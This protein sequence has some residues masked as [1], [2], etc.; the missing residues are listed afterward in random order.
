M[1]PFTVQLVTKG[2]HI[3]QSTAE[4]TFTSAAPPVRKA[5]FVVS[6]SK[7]APQLEYAGLTDVEIPDEILG[8]VDF[9]TYYKRVEYK[10][11]PDPDPLLTEKFRWIQCVVKNQTQFPIQVQGPPYFDSGR[12][13]TPP[14]DIE[15]FD[16]MVFSCS[17]GDESLAGV[18]GGTAFRIALDLVTFYD[19]AV[20]WTSPTVGGFKASIVKSDNP[21]IAYEQATLEGNA[22][23]SKEVFRGFQKNGHPVERQIYMSAA[24]GQYMIYVITEV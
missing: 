23:K 6:G 9:R 24:A 20:G 21:R 18:T 10:P 4:L 3:T 16:Q 17:N 11:I 1:E 15:P 8:D 12:Y 2:V 19:F 13:W 7:D 22:L 5:K 14:T